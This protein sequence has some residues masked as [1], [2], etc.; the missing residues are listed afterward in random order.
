MGSYLFPTSHT[1][2]C[3]AA[4]S[5]RPACTSFCLLPS[6]P[7]FCVSMALVSAPTFLSVNSL[8]IIFPVVLLP[9]PSWNVCQGSLIYS[10]HSYN[11]APP[12]LPGI[13]L[14]FISPFLC[15]S[16]SPSYCLFAYLKQECEFLQF[17]VLGWAL[18][19]GKPEEEILSKG[20]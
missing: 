6:L 14:V 15:L 10:H 20:E 13:F 1:S 7:P 19:R 5:S 12:P 18:L 3:C 8:T 17:K 11:H 4:V 2:L 9:F 16:P